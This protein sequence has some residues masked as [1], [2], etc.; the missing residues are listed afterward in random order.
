[1]VFQLFTMHMI[2]EIQLHFS[3]SILFFRLYAKPAKK[4]LHGDAAEKRLP[5]FIMQV[6]QRTITDKTD[7]N[8]EVENPFVIDTLQPTVCF[9]KIGKQ[10]VNIGR[11]DRRHFPG[12]HVPEDFPEFPAG[13]KV[14]AILLLYREN[15]PEHLLRFT[16]QAFPVS[17]IILQLFLQ[18]NAFHKRENKR[19]VLT[20]NRN[21]L[22]IGIVILHQRPIVFD[23]V[24]MCLRRGLC[25]PLCNIL[26][27]GRAH[28]D[29]CSNSEI[30]FSQRI[31]FNI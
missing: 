13:F 12:L 30:R 3:I 9:H 7:R 2:L 11:T 29:L 27:P 19:I 26:F 1:M 17:V 4:V 15:S 10:S 20:L 21:Q 18:G 22:N 14:T 31:V 25:R 24:D 23:R 5:Q 28:S 16:D 8:T 6:S